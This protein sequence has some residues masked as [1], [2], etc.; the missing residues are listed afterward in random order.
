MEKTV[1]VGEK[2]YKLKELSYVQ[3][4][5][6]DGLT[7]GEA[8]KKVLQFSAGLSDEE[9]ANLSIKDGIALQEEINKINELAQDFQKPTEENKS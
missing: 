5:E 3:V 4:L 9:I 1:K 2:E 8:A 6:L 7:K